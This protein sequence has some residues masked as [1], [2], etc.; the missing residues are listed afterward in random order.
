[1]TPRPGNFARWSERYAAGP[2]KLAVKRSVPTRIL[3]AVTGGLERAQRREGMHPVDHPVSSIARQPASTW[4]E[5]DNFPSHRSAESGRPGNLW[6]RSDRL[7]AR[8]IRVLHR[9]Q[10]CEKQPLGIFLTILIGPFVVGLAHRAR[11]DGALDPRIRVDVVGMIIT[12]SIP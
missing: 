1:M 8:Q 3:L 10:R 5:L 2:P 6:P 4:V 9:Q 7:P 12:W 11:T